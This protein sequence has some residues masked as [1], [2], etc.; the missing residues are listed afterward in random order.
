MNVAWL[1][2]SLTLDGNLRGVTWSRKPHVLLDFDLRFARTVVAK[3]EQREGNVPRVFFPLVLARM[4][5]LEML[6]ELVLGREALA[7][8]MNRAREES[9]LGVS[10]NVSLELRLVVEER[11]TEIAGV[12]A[13]RS[14]L[15]LDRDAMCAEV[16]VELRHRVKLSRTLTAH[17]LL[18]LVVR[19]HVI[20]EVGNLSKGSSAVV[21]DAHKRPLAGVESSVVVEIRDLRECF[22]AV[23]AKSQK[24]ANQ[25]VENSHSAS[26]AYQTYGRSL[27]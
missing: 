1:R 18:D 4:L 9:P 24:F 16:V 13:A 27:V 20:V 25:Q 5:M 8:A 3:L 6:V 10:L 19:L 22:A 15:H 2:L 7:A 12:L 17:V 21:L 11:R 23:V 26:D 14:N